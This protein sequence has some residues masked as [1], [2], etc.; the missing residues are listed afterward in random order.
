MCP[1]LSLKINRLKYS[2]VIG[3]ALSE[4]VVANHCGAV[5]C[6][7]IAIQTNQLCMVFTGSTKVDCACIMTIQLKTT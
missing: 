4:I 5:N 1:K 7:F 2:I 3:V 6:K